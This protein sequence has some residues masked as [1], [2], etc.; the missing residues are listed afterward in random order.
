MEAALQPGCRVVVPLGGGHANG[1][2]A[3]LTDTPPEG[4]RLKEILEAVDPVPLVDAARLELAR[5]IAEAYFAP[6]GECIRLF[7]PP[8]SY[9]ETTFTYRATEAGRAHLAAGGAKTF[10]DKVLALVAARPGVSRKEIARTIPAAGMDGLLAGL[11]RRGLLEKE[12]RVLGA[13]TGFRRLRFVELLAP[14]VD[15][16][17]YPVRQRAVLEFL[18]S[19]QGPLPQSRVLRETNAVA[20][21]L[22]SLAKKGLLRVYEEES[23]RDPFHGYVE[24]HD[25][26]LVLTAAQRAAVDRVRGDLDAGTPGQYLL[27]GITGSGKTQVYIELIHDALARG[28]TALVLVPEIALTPALTRRFL[29]HFGPRLAILHSML[30]DGERHDQWFRIHRGEARVVIGTRSALFAPLERPGLIVMDEEHDASYKQ[31]E[32]PRY[33]AREVARRWAAACGAALVLGSATP[34]LES[35]HAATEGGGLTLLEL[36]ER[37]E[38]R[39]LPEVTLVDMSQEFERHGKNVILAGEVHRAVSER[40]QRREQVMVLLNRRG[41]APVVLCRKCGA[42]VVCDHCAVSLTFHQREQKLLCHYCGFLRDVPRE[43]PE[44]GSKYLFFLGTG[45][46]KLEEAFRQRFPGRTVARF[47]RDT[48]RRRGQMK[49]ILD[50]FENREIDLLVGTQMIAKG[51]DFPAV[52]LVVVLSTD[53]SLRIPDLRAAERTFQLLTQVAGR[54]GRGDTP[55]QVYIQTYFPN[56]YAVRCA[57]RQDYRAFYQQEIAYRRRMF[58]PPFTRLVFIRITERSEEA[59][60][61]LAAIAGEH[62]RA[63][64]QAGDR[65]S[66]LRVTGPMPALLEKVYDEWRW[67]LLVRCLSVEGLGGVL[68]D[69]RRRC[70]EA[71]LPLQRLAVDIDPMDLT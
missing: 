26:P 70:A 4:V 56:H 20:P 30:S 3:R 22:Q 50:R 10:P 61:R 67:S 62:L 25:G 65:G 31:D 23:L 37:I 1:V 12:A 24:R 2:V 60:R 35:F 39:P 14:D 45:T 34:S 51:H 17:G 66:T 28:R 53:T 48:T 16:A 41:Y 27:F 49:E 6:P 54:S 7:F 18:R 9:V 36:P 29:A 64:I 19:H 13:R 46:E 55:G 71:R 58:F 43:C 33:H 38:R 5:W 32:T 44:C 21:V 57:R 68:H 15:P 63:A 52:T 8:G 42:D 40:M 11:E 59:V 69:F 47:D